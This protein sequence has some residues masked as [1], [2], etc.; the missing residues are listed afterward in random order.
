MTYDAGTAAV[1]V[2]PTFQN[3]QNDI[4][5]E[6]QKAGAIAGRDFSKEFSRIVRA[7]LGD[8]PL[9]GPAETKSK[10]AAAGGS[11]ADSFRRRVEAALKSL[12]DIKVNADTS[13]A[14][15]ALAAVRAELKDLASKTIGVDVDAGLALA[16]LDRIKAELAR[17]SAESPNIAV[18]IDAALA[19]AEIDKIHAQVNS[20][21]RDDVNIDVN[22]NG[23]AASAGLAAIGAEASSGS[24]GFSALAIAGASLAPIII[25]AAAAAAAAIAAIGSAAAVGLAGIGVLALG[26][27]GITDAVSAM[28]AAQAEAGKAGTKSAAD[29]A[30]KQL[31][32]AGAVDAVNSAEA[33]LANARAN[34]ADAATAAARRVVT[35]QRDV[36]DAVRGVRDAERDVAAAQQDARRA[37]LA[38]TQAREDAKR[39][40]Q[41]LGTR[42]KELDL[43]QR[44][45]T[46]SQEQAKND[47]DRVLMDPK[48]NEF[49]RAQARLT[50]DEATQRIQSLS[51]EQ[52]RAQDDKAKA[53]KAGIEG[54]KQVI[55]AQDGIKSANDRVVQAQQKLVDAQR[56]VGD[57][58]QKVAIAVQEQTKQ[59]RQSAFSIAQAQ[60]GVISAQR[61]LQQ[62]TIATSVA[63]GSAM[64]KLRQAMAKLSPEG[65]KFAKFLF[66]L[67]PVLDNLKATAANGLLPGVTAG[68][69]AAMPALPAITKLV[70]TLAKVMGELFTKAGQALGSPF[71]T[72]FFDYL[73][74]IAGP[75]LDTLFGSLLNLGQGF[76]SLLMAFTPVNKDLGA[77]LLDLTKKFADWAASLGQSDGFKAFIAYIQDNGPKIVQFLLDLGGTFGKLV[78]LMAPLGAALLDIAAKF[79]NWLNSLTPAQFAA[80]TYGIG[81]VAVAIGILVVVLTTAAAP[82][83]L[84]VVGITL[85]IGA[86]LWAYKNISWFHTAV[87]AVWKAISTAALWLWNVILKPVFTAIGDFI[88]KSVAPAV[89]WLWKNVIQPAFSAI[90]AI[91][92]WAWNNV[93][94]PAF[95]FI[96]FFITNVLAPVFLWLWRNVISPAWTGIRIAISVAWAIIKVIFGL[97]QIAIRV[98]GGVFDWLYKNVIKPVWDKISAAISW[99]W[100]H[101]LKPLFS[102][103][104]N[105]IK[106]KVAPAFAKGVEAIGKAWDKIK[107][108]AKI[109]IKFVVDTV[110]NKGIIDNFNK[111][112][113]H[114]GVSK[115]DH[116]TLPKGFA[117]GGSVWGGTPG[118]DSVPA[119]LMPGEHVMTA[120]EVR[121]AGGHGAIYRLRQSILE[122]NVPRFAKGGG[123]F[124][125]VKDRLGD[126]KSKAGKVIS[127]ITG[128][129]TDPGGT[130]KKIVASLVGLLPGGKDTAFGKLATAVPT[131][132]IDNITG[133]MK[134]KFAQIGNFFSAGS[135][136][137]GGPSQAGGSATPSIQSIVGLANASGVPFRVTST[138][139]PGSHSNSGGLDDHSRGLAVDMASSVPNMVKLA[140]FF[141]RFTPY[142]RELIHSGGGG[143]FV[144]NGQR[145]GSSF[146]RSEIAGHYNHVHVSA[147]QEAIARGRKALGYDSGGM[148]PPGY[149]TVFNG[150]SKPEPVL[151]TQQFT[152]LHEAARSGGAGG[153][154][155]R[156]DVND[157]AVSGL[158]DIGIESAFGSL[159]DAKIYST[160]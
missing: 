16:Q 113:G 62:A 120:Q 124:D 160:A 48:A 67:K 49:Q 50:Y 116:V 143:F 51:V 154:T 123:V 112:A 107:E 74:S 4:G 126:L 27:S 147:T 44:R 43:E 106:E 131:K 40:L 105:F 152:N 118:K 142:L 82:W 77:G 42:V 146:Y 33:S 145:V 23:A 11:F 119:L 12:P 93:I 159:A 18:Q 2:V 134:D 30:R 36:Q 7:S 150:T 99:V 22:V 54:S 144:K 139:R 52:Q 34:A 28:G 111:L 6:F 64:E 98:L 129:L 137:G 19:T 151:T 104:G 1:R 8:L 47:L 38:L 65:Q 79:L 108:V 14:D 80:L 17:I 41:D 138:Y 66:G 153:M 92:S 3:L 58:N 149:S 53:D 24:S 155:I 55:Q 115:V 125:W 85:M 84:I 15:L 102:T 35:A 90:G 13:N 39:S 121:K 75:T 110:I 9:P 25:P 71:W 61:S 101:V 57:A 78:V 114:F 109:P 88:T 86:L 100:D 68:I 76:A 56:A 72:K 96:W 73:S 140:Q 37:Q 81:A 122:G 157:G 5:R 63:G 117:E 21:D 103:I 70:G 89:I 91:I 10:G 133:V 141:M 135:G 136:G 148:L 95:S 83:T 29:I 127:G 69:K 132:L 156:V 60:Q 32:V 20:L 26:F 158:I 31:Q 87:D 59:Q 46:L 94:K 45:A 97:I 130:L 128:I